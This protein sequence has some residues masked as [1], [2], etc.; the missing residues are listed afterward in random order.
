MPTA[1]GGRPSSRSAVRGDNLTGTPPLPMLA[2]VMVNSLTRRYYA[3]VLLVWILGAVSL[4]AQRFWDATTILELRPQAV[5]EEMTWSRN[6]T[7]TANGL[8]T[9]PRASTTSVRE[10]WL[11]TPP[12]ATGPSW[13]P[14]DNIT[15]SM[16]LDDVRP[17]QCRPRPLVVMVSGSGDDIA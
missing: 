16:T 14:P 9:G 3:A 2:S 8:D 13:G 7:L 1:S 15:I 12:L 11:Q 4:G 10:F 17:L 6:L 5:S